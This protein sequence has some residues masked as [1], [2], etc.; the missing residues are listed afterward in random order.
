MEKLELSEVKRMVCDRLDIQTSNISLNAR[1]SKNQIKVFANLLK[2]VLNN[3][4]LYCFVPKESTKI[5]DGVWEYDISSFKIYQITKEAL[6]N[7]NFDV[8]RLKQCENGERLDVFLDNSLVIYDSNKGVSVIDDGTTERKLTAKEYACLIL[9][10]PESGT[11]WL[12]QL[13]VKKNRNKLL[14]LSV[15]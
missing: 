9:E 15:E 4:P 1:M 8:E 10:L 11:R 12:D 7:I 5:K 14:N 6:D 2:N 3:Q 13:I